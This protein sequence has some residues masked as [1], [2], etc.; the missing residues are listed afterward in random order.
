MYILPVYLIPSGVLFQA[1]VRQ[2]ALPAS[3]PQVWYYTKDW[4]FFPLRDIDLA[5]FALG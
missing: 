2:G 1:Q 5:P 4:A 3:G